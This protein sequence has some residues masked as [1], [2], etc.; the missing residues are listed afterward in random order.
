M[1]KHSL[2]I[3]ILFTLFSCGGGGGSSETKNIT[4]PNGNANDNDSWTAKKPVYTGIRDSYEITQSNSSETAF[5]VVESLDLLNMLAFGDEYSHFYFLKENQSEALSDDA[6]CESG[7]VSTTEVEPQK[8]IEVKYDHCQIDGTEINGTLRAINN[9]GTNDVTILPNI[10]IK[11]IAT[12][13]IESL[14]GY[15]TVTP[16]DSAVFHLII[17]SSSGEQLWFDNF[18]INISL[19][20]DNYG[21]YFDGDIYISDKGKL[22]ISTSELGHSLY[23]SEYY[24]SIIK[25]TSNEEITLNLQL[26]HLLE[27]QSSEQFIPVTIPLTSYPENLFNDANI[28]PQ[29][30]ITNEESSVDRNSELQLSSL[31]SFDEDYDFLTFY[32]EVTSK[33]DGSLEN[34]TRAS[35]LTFSADLPGDYTI[36]LTVEDSSG[37]SSF[38]DTVVTVLKNIPEGNISF[39]QSENYISQNFNASVNLDNDQFDGPFSYRLKYG[40]ANMKISSEGSISWDGLIPDFGKPTDVNFAIYIENEHKNAVL[41]K[42]VTLKSSSDV[43]TEKRTDSAYVYWNN[44]FQTAKNNTDSIY[45]GGGNLS[46]FIVEGT[47]LKLKDNVLISELGNAKVNYQA[48]SDVDSDGTDDYWFSYIDSEKEEYLVLWKNGKTGIINEFLSFENITSDYISL[49]FIDFNMDGNRDLFVS[50]PEFGTK[51][52]NVSNKE[53]VLTLESFHRDFDQV[54]DFN[55]DG[56]LDFAYSNKVLDIKN[57]ETLYESDYYFQTV[58][59]DGDNNCEIVYINE[60]EE[61]VLSYINEV[62]ERVI[63]DIAVFQRNR[64]SITVGNFDGEIG[65]EVLIS[66]NIIEQG[67]GTFYSIFMISNLSSENLISQAITIDEEIELNALYSVNAIADLDN[68]GRDE[69]IFTTFD[70]SKSLSQ[71][72]SYSIENNSIV[73]EYS[74]LAYSN[75]QF[76]IADWQEDDTLTFLSSGINSVV[77]KSKIDLPV[78]YLLTSSDPKAVS[79]ENSTT[80]IYKS[81]HPGTHITKQDMYAN[82]YWSVDIQQDNGFQVYDLKILPNGLLLAQFYNHSDSLISS[83]TGEILLT[84]P[85]KHSFG[86]TQFTYYSN[87]NFDY[88]ASM[89]TQSLLKI[90]SDNTLAEITND[91]ITSLLQSSNHYTFAQYDNDLLPE[92]IIYSTF[93]KTYKV[94]DLTTGEE[95]V[96]SDLHDGNVEKYSNVSSKALLQ[97]FTW[98]NDCRNFIS[99][100]QREDGFEVVDKFTGTIIWRSPSFGR[101]ILGVKF[102]KEDNKIYSGLSFFDG[103]IYT[104]KN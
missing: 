2:I 35:V 101:H 24:T 65:D 100:E 51:I 18:K 91:T 14:N 8:K 103:Y 78:D 85:H 52:I 37:S 60:N 9:A 31:N 90:E 71:H 76:N 73:Q 45:F 27:V 97:C 92:L 84:L 44:S 82:E 61:L 74:S 15:L 23:S 6:V 102:R 3:L 94:L 1:F 69:L 95:E 48:V 68:D 16:S 57:N 28:A 22:S 62:K 67:I 66:G 72:K 79:S 30:V 56:Y 5:N 21:M 99:N 80:Y 50:N 36:R 89:R 59:V 87:E 46:Q 29:A 47:N 64:T 49:Q 4:P 58:N 13:E 63:F 33:P 55:S 96:N 70:Y 54:C 93:N 53:E 10:S 17:S 75:A 39:S 77:A 86:G 11:D 88:Y 81:Q 83:Y 42:T 26:Q 38:T 40:P 7:S 19:Y 34:L 20:G 41:T 104:F 32:W 12:G 98:D 43:I 25:I